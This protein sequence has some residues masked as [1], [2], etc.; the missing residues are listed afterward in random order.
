MNARHYI[1][2]F[3]VDT[4]LVDDDFPDDVSLLRSGIIGPMG[5]AI[6]GAFLE[7]T[8]RIRVGD[9]ELVESNL[10]SIERAAA[11]VERK[12]SRQAVA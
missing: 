1:R 3:I 11:F 7:E 6:L 4:F 12:N 10:D 2:A 9:D 8:F 5:L